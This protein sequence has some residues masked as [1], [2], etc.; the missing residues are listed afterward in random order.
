MFARAWPIALAVFSDVFYQI[1]SK[2]TPPN[3]N[4]FAS[5]TLT[6][7]IGAAV[8][9]IA[10]Y[11]SSG[12]GNVLAE[13]KNANWSALLLGLAIVGLEGGSIFMYKAGWAVNTGYVIKAIFIA[14][15]LVFV[16]W[17]VYKEPISLSKIA[18]IAFCMVGLFL[19]NR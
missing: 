12:G 14:V 8:T 18:G 11:L 3:V 16:G 7:L 2:S 17:F 10:F 4:V 6:Y 5:L 15:A 13:M 1:G 9:L 19:I